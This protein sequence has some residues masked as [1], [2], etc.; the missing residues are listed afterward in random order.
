MWG[1][2]QERIKEASRTKADARAH[3]ESVDMPRASYL[4][5][6]QIYQEQLPVRARPQWGWARGAAAAVLHGCAASPGATRAF[7]SCGNF[8]S[9]VGE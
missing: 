8:H 4:Q 5:L 1:A 9:T 2:A 6:L 3:G 7:K